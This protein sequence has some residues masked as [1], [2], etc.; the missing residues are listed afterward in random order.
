MIGGTVRA[1]NPERLRPSSEG[2]QRRWC[3]SRRP[4]FVLPLRLRAAREFLGRETNSK[5]LFDGLAK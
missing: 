3:V 1:R 4:Q 5:A 2:G